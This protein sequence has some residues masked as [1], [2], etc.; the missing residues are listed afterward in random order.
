MQSYWLFLIL[1]AIALSTCISNPPKSF[2]PTK[3]V[4]FEVSKTLYTNVGTPV[5]GQD[6]KPVPCIPGQVPAKK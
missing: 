4:C 6:G 5:L 3:T 1:T 2:D